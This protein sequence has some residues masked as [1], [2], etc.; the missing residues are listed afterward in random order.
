MV[1]NSIITSLGL[2]NFLALS[3]IVI[4]GLPHGAFDGAIASYLGFS[5]RP[6][7][8][9]RFLFM[10]I[11]LTILVVALWIAFPTT[12]LIIFLGV[13]IIHFGL[14]DARVQNGWF[15][16]VQAIAHGGIVITVIAQWHKSN[17]SKIFSYLTGEE[18]LQVWIAIDILSIIVVTMIIIYA[19]Q[20]ICNR[21]HL[22][23][24]LEILFLILILSQLPPLVGFAIYFC[25]FHSVRHLLNIW[26]SIN[27]NLP[28]NNLYVQAI[29]YT[30]TSWISGWIAFSWC[31]N[32]L[33]VEVSLLRV[34]FIGLAALTVPHMMLVDIFFRN[35]TVHLKKIF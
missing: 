23:G 8:F 17:V 31:I 25:C 2:I 4:I 9:I 15:R 14:G 19:W 30:L 16:W 29:G 21:R 28:R 24:L 22:V 33:S 5:K 10:Y 13:S 7:L 1:S 3:S 18:S 35:H 6:G 20:A 11:T 34:V 27:A 12:S 32:Q 26:R